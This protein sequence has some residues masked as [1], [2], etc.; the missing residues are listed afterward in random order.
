MYDSTVSSLAILKVNWD[1]RGRDFIENFVPF[2]A[3]CLRTAPHAAVA[4][5]DLQK[6]VAESFGLRIPQ[7]A[8]KTILNRVVREGYA[9]RQDGIYYRDETA[10]AGLEIARIR[11]DVL[12]QHEA[13]IDRLLEFCHSEHDVTWSREEG[14]VA[15]LTYVQERSTSLLAAAISGQPLPVPIPARRVEHADFLV[16]SFVQRLHQRDPSGFA[17][18]ESIVK[19]SMLANVL[20]FPDLGSVPRAFERAEMYFDTAFLIRA[21]GL[22]GEAA[23]APCRELLDLLRQEGAQLRCFEHT[24]DEL[25]GVLDHVARALASPPRPRPPAVGVLEYFI[26]SNLRPSDVEMHLSKLSQSLRSLGIQVRPMPAHQVELSVDEDKLASRLMDGVGYRRQDTL[27]HDA[28][29]LTAIHRLRRGRAVTRLE[30][31]EALFV[32]TNAPLV[33]VATRFFR[34]EYGES[35]ATCV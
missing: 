30:T 29:A 20:L 16:N 8:L 21:L 22:E 17:F 32:T 35:F 28:K 23:Q 5:C 34:E 11:D 33:R 27:E 2:V 10:L 31:C 25:R 24:V 12:R 18:M 3:E 19:G 14:E 9:R 13:L 7:G 6:A 4:L 26:R 1:K 15:L